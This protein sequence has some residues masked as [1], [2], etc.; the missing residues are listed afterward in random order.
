MGIER[1]ITVTYDDGT[2]DLQKESPS[3]GIESPQRGGHSF[4]QP[5]PCKKSPQ[6]WGLKARNLKQPPQSHL[7]PCK[8]S[9]QAWGLKGDRPLYQC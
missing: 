1:K 4:P 5:P 7:M 9:P 2:S 6:A 8:K 3:M